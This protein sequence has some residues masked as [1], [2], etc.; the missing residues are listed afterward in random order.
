MFGFVYVFDPLRIAL[1]GSEYRMLDTNPRMSG[2]LLVGGDTRCPAC[3]QGR[4]RPMVN[5]RIGGERRRPGAVGAPL[6]KCGRPPRAAASVE[7]V[8]KSGH[9]NASPRSSFHNG[10]TGGVRAVRGVGGRP[11]PNAAGVGVALAKVKDA[12]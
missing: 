11:A 2:V 7:V 8:A 4:P 5:V 10:S 1:A 3:R 6:R 12:H 9:K